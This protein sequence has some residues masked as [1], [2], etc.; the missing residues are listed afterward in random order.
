MNRGG[1]MLEFATQTRQ[2][3]GNQCSAQPA[4]PER[5]RCAVCD[6]KVMLVSVGRPD[7]FRCPR[8][9]R[10]YDFTEDTGAPHNNPAIAAEMNEARRYR[11]RQ[12][13]RHPASQRFLQHGGK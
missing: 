3:A 11:E 5:R 9:S 12:S 7:E 8:C 13:N 4:Q 10:L 6:P 1:K 2:R